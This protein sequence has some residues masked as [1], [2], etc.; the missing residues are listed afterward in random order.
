M[1]NI[2]L[3]DLPSFL[4]TTDPNDIMLSFII[5]K[6]KACR[7]ASAM[8]L[9]TYDHLEQDVL[10]A[11]SSIN[12]HLYT[13][14]PLHLLSNQIKDEKL[15]A[16]GSN[17]WA[18]E[19]ECIEW[20]NSREPNSVVYVNFGSVTVMT[21]QQLIEFAWGLADSGKPFLWIVRPDLIVGDLV[22]LPNE[23]VAETKDRSLIASWCCQEQVLNHPSVEG[24]FT[25][26]GWN[27]L[28]KVYVLEWR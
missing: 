8:I 25:H 6:M 1:K 7:E 15:R 9:N 28:W 18:E 10:D 3:R 20:L 4:R 14:G 13:I 11:L 24:F 21:A 12:P 22:I 27:S 16:I 17:L 2:R 5:Q 23:F 26:S 19:S